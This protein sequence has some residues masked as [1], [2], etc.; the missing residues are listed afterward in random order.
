[1]TDS[2]KDALLAAMYDDTEEPKEKRQLR[3]DHE[4]VTNKK[5]RRI[6]VGIVGYDVPTPEYVESLEKRLVQQER[7]IMEQG[8]ALKRFEIML[9]ALRTALSKQGRSVNDMSHELDRKIDRRDF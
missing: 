2:E 6:A 7:V 1:M 5:V 9:N 4:A 3:V 8:R